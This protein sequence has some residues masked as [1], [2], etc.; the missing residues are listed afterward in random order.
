MLF[1]GAGSS[2]DKGHFSSVCRVRAT[3]KQA[4]KVN[5]GKS[6]EGEQWVHFDDELVTVLS[7]KELNAFM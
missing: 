6:G 2:C 4:L 3:D 1:G 5:E 7:G